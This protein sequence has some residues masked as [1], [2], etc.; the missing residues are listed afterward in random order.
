MDQI[1]EA[2]KKGLDL[3]SSGKTWSRAWMNA[4]KG[5]WRCSDSPKPFGTPRSSRHENYGSPIA[6]LVANEVR[7]IPIGGAAAAAQRFRAR[8]SSSRSLTPAQAASA[9]RAFS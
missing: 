8:A 3:S 7:F 1:I 5:T 9:F 2:Y 4:S 6:L